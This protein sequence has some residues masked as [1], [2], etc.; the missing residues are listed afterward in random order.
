MQL[1]RPLILGGRYNTISFPRPT[2]GYRRTVANLIPQREAPYT[3]LYRDHAS[4]NGS[5]FAGLRV[6]N[7]YA[8][9]YITYGETDG[10]AHL[11]NAERPLHSWLEQ[12]GYDYE[13]ITNLDLHRDPRVLD[14][15][16]AVILVGHD[17]Y[18][19]IPQ[20]RN[21]EQYL[22]RGGKLLVMAGNVGFWRVSLNDD[23]SVM[24]C[25]KADAPGNRVP[26]GKRGERIHSQDKLAGGLGRETATP[27]WRITGL[28][29]TSGAARYQ[30]HRMSPRM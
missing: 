7:P 25:R 8:D 18:W 2:T 21:M 11:L 19:S 20:Y 1:L 14:R 15:R 29:T 3:S 16:S 22:N 4:G 5:Y 28:E 17:E 9:P 10:A 30:E 13:V 12:E 26:T 24:E 23:L 27:A 6:P